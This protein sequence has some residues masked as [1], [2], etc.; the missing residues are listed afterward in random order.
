MKVIDSKVLVQVEK[1]TACTQK[2]GS[3]SVPVG[4]GEFEIATV[5]GVGEKVDSE[6]LKEG[7]RIYIYPGV[8]KK[9][10]HEMKE[11]RVITLNEII[12]VL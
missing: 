6:I 3:L 9:F 2:V 1:E 4:A 10:T 11:Y 7:D 5:L 8:G 12:V